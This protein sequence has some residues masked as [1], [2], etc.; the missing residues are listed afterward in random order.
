M[1]YIITLFA[2][3]LLASIDLSQDI[4]AVD[5]VYTIGNTFCIIKPAI[6]QWDS[7]YRCYEVYYEKGVGHTDLYYKEKSKDGKIIY[8]E[9]EINSETDKY[10]GKF[11]F[12]NIK[13][14]TGMYDRADGKVFK[15][16]KE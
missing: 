8:K 2:L 13:Y 9:Y 12:D 5:G 6:I 3:M 16:T 10:T 1:K 11:I 15:V 14:L 7:I 4:G